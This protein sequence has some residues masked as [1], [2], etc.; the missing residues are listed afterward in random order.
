MTFLTFLEDWGAVWILCSTAVSERTPQ[1]T[2][3]LHHSGENS[4]YVHN[5]ERRHVSWCSCVHSRT[6]S[7]GWT[8]RQLQLSCRASLFRKLQTLL[9]TPDTWAHTPTLESLMLIFPPHAWTMCSLLSLVSSLTVSPEESLVGVCM[10]EGHI[11]MW[12]SCGG[13]VSP[14]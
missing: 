6:R 2:A 3:R 9:K 7:S 4:F 1:V 14:D 10:T 5:W 13:G 8:G 11:W 12:S